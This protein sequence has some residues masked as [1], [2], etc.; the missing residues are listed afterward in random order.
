MATLNELK[1]Q[2]IIERAL[3]SL[4]AWKAAFRLLEGAAIECH[5]G[6][7]K[8]IELVNDKINSDDLIADKRIFLEKLYEEVKDKRIERTGKKATGKLSLGTK[9]LII[10]DDEVITNGWAEIL[11]LILGKECKIYRNTFDF[12]NEIKTNPQLFDNVIGVFVDLKLP[13]SE[14]TGLALMRF[15]SKKYSHVPVI[16]FSGTKSVSFIKQAFES[17]IWDYFIKDPN[18]DEFKE[19]VLYY[20]NFCKLINRLLDY[21]SKYTCQYW[22]PITALEN[23]LISRKYYDIKLQQSITD[24]LKIAY[25]YLIIDEVNRFAPDFLQINKAEQITNLA[26]QALETFCNVYL[27]EKGAITDERGLSL[28]DKIDMTKIFTSS[29]RSDAQDIRMLRND[30]IHQEVLERKTG[31]LVKKKT[32]Q[33]ADAEWALLTTI[34]ICDVAFEKITAPKK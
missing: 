9:E 34:Q 5:V 24:K 22:K 19:P 11:K 21:D 17:G 16:G 10:V 31:R 28:R 4:K 2:K 32:I 30:G 29:Q 8:V 6:K 7:N 12:Q 18:E 26:G 1:K 3:H 14:K 13:V 33:V 25:K 20:Q 15:I 27:F 23:K